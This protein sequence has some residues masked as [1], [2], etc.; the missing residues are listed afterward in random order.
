MSKVYVDVIAEFTKE[1]T[2][3]P[4][5]IGWRDGRKFE[6]DKVKDVRRAASLRAGGVGMRYTCMISGQEKYL[7]YEDN[8][9][10]FVEGRE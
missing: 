10:W 9:L 7:Y 6:I 1:G 5:M 2:L 8:N 4:I 3:F